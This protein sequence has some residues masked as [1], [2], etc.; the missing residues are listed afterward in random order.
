MKFSPGDLVCIKTSFGAVC[1]GY[2]GEYS[3]RLDSKEIFIK[4]GDPLL[5]VRRWVWSA[6]WPDWNAEVLAGD[7]LLTVD[8]YRLEKFKG[9]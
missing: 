8:S 7:Q 1:V 9:K 5:F 2:V 6:L 4:P 3:N